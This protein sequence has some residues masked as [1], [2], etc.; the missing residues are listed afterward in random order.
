MIC[1]SLSQTA[2]AC[3]RPVDDGWLRRLWQRGWNPIS[4]IGSRQGRPLKLR[5]RDGWRE[6]RSSTLRKALR[7]SDWD[8]GRIRGEAA[9]RSRHMSCGKH[10]CADKFH[11]RVSLLFL[12][13]LSA[14]PI[15]P[16]NLVHPCAFSS[17]LAPIW[18][19]LPSVG[20]VN[21]N[22]APRPVLRLAHKRPPCD[23]IILRLIERPMPL[24]CGLVVK[25]ASKM[26]SLS[27]C[28][29]PIPASLTEI[30][31]SPSRVALDARPS[32]PPVSFMASMPHQVH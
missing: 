17:T 14:S 9:G 13:P 21:S 12:A 29:R 26:R 23:S 22:V 25:N 8:Q 30:T 27:C 28:G 20:R 1:L 6:A 2:S 15:L 16:Q 5:R 24:P 7:M 18:E 19:R 3:A 11:D 32:S 4:Q 10:G 31:T